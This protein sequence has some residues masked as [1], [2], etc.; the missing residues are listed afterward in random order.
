MPKPTSC[1]LRLQQAPRRHD[2]ETFMR[3]AQ[4]RSDLYLEST[5]AQ[6]TPRFVPSDPAEVNDLLYTLRRDARCT[7]RDFLEWGCGFATAAGLAHLNGFKAK[8]IE[9]SPVLAAGARTLLR[10]FDLPVDIAEGDMIPRWLSTS[11][12]AGVHD[13]ELHRD[14]PRPHPLAPSDCGPAYEALGVSTEDIDVFFAYPWPGEIEM[15]MNLFAEVSQPG[16][17]LA[18]YLGTGETELWRNM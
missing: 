9:M 17:W 2:I 6:K 12:S 4:E 1:K 18:L 13:Q 5:S 3:V 14:A 11:A 15:I 7:G 16:A 10:E 8:G